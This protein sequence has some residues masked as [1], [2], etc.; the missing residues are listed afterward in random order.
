MS[1]F[2]VIFCGQKKH[3]LSV[4]VCSL[5]Q[6]SPPDTDYSLCY[7]RKWLLRPM[8][9]SIWAGIVWGIVVGLH[10]LR[11][12]LNGNHDFFKTGPPVVLEDMPVA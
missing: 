1:S 6:Q 3:V 8:S 7:P 9:V 12:G 2:V 5:P 10:L 4:K 11:E